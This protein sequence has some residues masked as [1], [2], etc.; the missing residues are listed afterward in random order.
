MAVFFVGS[1][2]AKRL[3]ELRILYFGKGVFLIY[4]A[5]LCISIGLMPFL[6]NSVWCFKGDSG[7]QCFG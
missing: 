1:T 6:T 4:H 3:L 7:K 2:K 5:A